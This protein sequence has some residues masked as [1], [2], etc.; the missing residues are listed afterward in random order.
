MLLT[1]LGLADW[2]V[3]ILGTDLNQQMVDRGGAGRYLQIEVNRGLPTPLP[4]QILQAA[5]R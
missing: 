2:N 1:E 4:G 5:G 3:Q